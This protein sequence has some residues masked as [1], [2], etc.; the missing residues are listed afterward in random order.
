MSD[1]SDI[2]VIDLSEKRHTFFSTKIISS[3]KPE[4]C[5]WIHK[6]LCLW[7]YHVF[8]AFGI[9][10]WM[11]VSVEHVLASVCVESCS[12]FIFYSLF[13]FFIGLF[14][15]GTEYQAVGGSEWKVRQGELGLHGIR[16]E[17][18]FSKF[19]PISVILKPPV[20]KG[21]S[22]LFFK[23]RQAETPKLRGL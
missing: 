3:W 15:S 5:T 1:R 2:Y 16:I 11:C 10:W 17:S 19:D 13:F 7:F 9:W 23:V 14:T 20:F 4:K 6:A 22:T 21:P 8:R 12:I 18:H